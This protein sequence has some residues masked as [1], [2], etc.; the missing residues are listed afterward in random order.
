VKNHNDTDF[1]T[2]SVVL[3]AEAAPHPED[4]KTAV[5]TGYNSTI[6]PI[7][8]IGIEST[9]RLQHEFSTLICIAESIQ[10]AVIGITFF[11]T[12]IEGY[13]GLE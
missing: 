5:F 8:P 6:Q 13:G 12:L 9:T 2:G 4:A 7:T 1:R 3:V 11:T 10:S